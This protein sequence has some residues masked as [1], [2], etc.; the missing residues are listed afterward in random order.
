MSASDSAP[1]PT[2]PESP[3]ASNTPSE[4]APR[5]D[6]LLALLPVAVA[7][8]LYLAVHSAPWTMPDAHEYTDLAATL[9]REGRFGHTEIG[10]ARRWMVYLRTPGYPALLALSAPLGKHG[11]LLVNLG[12]LWLLTLAGLRLARRWRLA[13]PGAIAALVA[14][15]PGLLT[16]ATMPMT[17]LTFAAL[18]W[19]AVVFVCERR[20]VPAALLL[21]AATLVRPVG[22]LLFVPFA[23]WCL[24]RRDRWT[25]VVLFLLLANAFQVGWA[26]RNYLHGGHFGY[27]TI[28]GYNL[29]QFKVGAWQSQRTGRPFDAVR[30][31]LT[32][33]LPPR[34]PD[35]GRWTSEHAG[36]RWAR[37]AAARRLAFDYISRDP[38]GIARWALGNA[39][40]YFMPD[41]SPLLQRLKIT[42]GQRGTY[43]VLRRQGVLP[44]LRH[45]FSG[46]PL[47][48]GAALGYTAWFVALG[49]AAIAG[50]VGAA[51]S[52]RWEPTYF[53][54]VLSIYFIGT[55][56]G[57]LDWRFRMPM[58][59]MYHLLAVAALGGVRP[60]A[61]AGPPQSTS[62]GTP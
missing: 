55:Q 54:V 50:L 6:R 39:P 42:R 1:Q 30:A 17:D 62:P 59:L 28:S 52:G 27:C 22:V 31:E 56:V 35:E 16:L 14:T 9:A 53:A 40:F 5:D 57:A 10:G 29:L 32:A 34:V 13:R 25:Q 47:A 46:Q 11:F 41:I 7:G 2:S 23:L 51:R 18:V 4:P 12:A 33:Q 19:W 26:G 24:L 48:A 58:A 37:S 21:S 43:D 8:L 3:P 15:T 61:P 44:A 45:Y 36:R 20:L 60:P 49:L 38:V